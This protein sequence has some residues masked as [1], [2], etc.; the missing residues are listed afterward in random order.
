[1]QPEN[2][3]LAVARA[4]AAAAAHTFTPQ[5]LVTTAWSLAVMG[6]DVLRATSFAALW[7]EMCA[8]GEA[9]ASADGADGAAPSYAPDVAGE[10]ITF[11]KWRGKHLN[12]IHQAA[13]SVA[14]AGGVEA[15]GL[16]PLPAPLATAAEVKPE[17]L[18]PKP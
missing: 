1:V 18:N 2:L 9:A 6:G 14:A 3:D 12:Q 17:T 16:P 15:L 10:Q 4:S 5:A 7:G 11:G 8:R 13:V